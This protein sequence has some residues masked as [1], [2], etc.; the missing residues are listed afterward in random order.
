MQNMSNLS[1]FLTIS[2]LT[3]LISTGLYAQNLKSIL[4]YSLTQDPSLKEAR[5]DQSA[6]KN[7]TKQARSQHLPTISVLGN[8]IV[9]QNHKYENDR[10]STKFTPS[11]Q[12]KLNLFSFGAIGYDVDKSLKDEEFYQY[13]YAE[14]KE[15][16]GYTIANLYLE[17]FKIKNAIEVTKRNLTRHDEILSD[18]KTIATNDEGRQ[19]E[20]AQAH[21]R[22]IL[23]EQEINRYN[24]EL[25]KIL[26]RLSKYTKKPVSP[27]DLYNPFEGLNNTTLFAKYSLKNKQDNASYKAQK[28]ELEKINFDHDA[29]KAKQLPS[30]NLVGNATRDDRELFLNMQWDIFNKASS[31]GVAEKASQI[32]AAEER[33]T[34]IDR[35]I[36]EKERLAKIDIK[37]NEIQLDT[38]K[39]QIQAS[40]DVVNY[41]QLQFSIARKTLIELLN[42]YNELASVELA[43]S[44]IE[45]SILQAKLD[46][47]HSQGTISQWVFG[48]PNKNIPKNSKK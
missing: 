22:Q 16:L 3:S 36:V 48:K 14:T 27:Q 33:L 25:A 17:A 38:V 11:V 40:Q 4:T 32:V 45:S 9:G 41:Y 23:V 31:Y 29:A 18:L 6:A 2:L 43:A 37:Q 39:K 19:S 34:R 35:D 12:G 42:S 8:Q 1:K 28:A 26:G 46:Y 21:A 15:E 13:K 47:L 44:N 20:Y 7:R 30:I 24:S 5:A 10:K